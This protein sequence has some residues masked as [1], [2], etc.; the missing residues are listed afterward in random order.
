MTSGKKSNNDSF[1]L[2]GMSSWTLSPELELQ[3]RHQSMLHFR[4]CP[5]VSL[6]ADGHDG[7]ADCPL[8]RGGNHRVPLRPDTLRLGSGGIQPV[9]QHRLGHWHRW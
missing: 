7:A 6:R 5:G 2:R 1:E 9:Q 4:A 8:L 3:N